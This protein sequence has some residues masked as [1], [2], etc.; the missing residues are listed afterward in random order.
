MAETKT[1]NQ[2]INLRASRQQK[3]LIDQAAD[4]LDRSRSD[5]M[6]DT[7]CREAAAL[8]ADQTHFALPEDKFKRFMATLDKPPAANPRLRKV[9]RTKASWER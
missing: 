2:I 1:R 9:L 3:R 8:L 4:L 5:F 6:L 7:A